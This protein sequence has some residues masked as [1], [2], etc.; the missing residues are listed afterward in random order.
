MNE[1]PNPNAADE[2]RDFI[3]E[4]VETDLAAG[5]HERIATRF[6]PEPNGY[7]HIGHAKSICLNFGIALQFD[8]ACHLRMD[9][10]NP[11]TEDEEYVRAIQ[12]DV[13]W[14]GF[15]WGEHEYFASN[16]FERLYELAEGLIQDGHAYVDSSTEEEIREHRGTIT[17]AGAPTPYRDRS[18][19]ESLDMFRRMRSGEFADGAHV[20]RA[21][22]DLAAPNMKMRDPLLYRIRHAHHYRTGD[23][24]CI[25]PLYDF[26]H[27]LSDAMEG[28]THSICTLEFENNREL[29]DWVIEHCRVDARPRQYEFARL[30]LTYTVMSKRKL[31]ELV[32]KGHVQGW[33]DPRMPTLAGMRRRGITPEAIRKFCDRI[34]VAKNNS[35]VDVALF[36]HTLRD[37]LSPRSPRMMAVMD[38]LEVVI[39]GLPPDTAMELE[40]PLWPPDIGKPGSRM[41]PLCNRLFIE[42]DDFS[43]NPPKGFHRL[44][45]GAK[46]RLRHADV[47][48]CDRVERDAAGKVTRLHCSAVAETEPG[49]RV[50][51][52]IHWVSAE[53]AKPVRVAVYDRLFRCEH[54]GAES[55]DPL[56]DLNE[57]SLTH[58]TAWAEPAVEA[59]APGSHVQ[60]ERLGYFF[61]DEAD[62]KK[63]LNRTVALKDSWAKTQ[64]RG[65]P[66]A[67]KARAKPQQAK[68]DPKGKEPLGSAAQALL[69]KHGIS[70]EDARVLGDDSALASFFEQ[71][72]SHHDSASTLASWLVN[73]LPGDHRG[74]ALAELPFGPKE[75]AQLVGLV[76]DSTITGAAGKKILRI[77]IEAGGSP[78]Q[79]V[80][81]RGLRQIADSSELLPVIE[82]VLNANT[83]TVQRYRDGNTKL[84]GAFVGMV[85]RETRG[86]ANPKLV[87][88]MLRD[89]LS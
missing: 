5:R 14:L 64:A 3:R 40:A 80:D 76:D 48:R 87:D 44:A 47:I 73:E 83:E 78:T 49:K 56:M 1:P 16:Y 32:Q 12:R 28:I 84:L 21:R 36:E 41:L 67:A 86:K 18:A 60:F 29:Y 37:D 24:W 75:F 51:G 33:D 55:G 38:P 9:D 19:E 23:T 72:L 74:S 43:E 50:K 70:A 77:L 42:R 85:M 27:P 22:I 57:H 81:E 31:L 79:I 69:S 35:T 66:A 82:R 17:E 30:N 34:G 68:V 15:D 71:A 26:V 61:V 25:Y 13:R 52:T 2:P 45:P 65:K 6:P 58:T 53:H 46:V 39:D 88:R 89:K 63:Q 59:L 62:G 7:L 54:P 20:L 8:G 4:I 11:T 10:S